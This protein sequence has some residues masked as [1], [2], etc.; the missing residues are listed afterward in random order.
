VIAKFVSFE[1]ITFR[2][3]VLSLLIVFNAASA[4]K[5]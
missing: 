2:K 1:I 3:F 4:D 5:I